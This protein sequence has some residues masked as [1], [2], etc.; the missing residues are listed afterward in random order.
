VC[1]GLSLG[2]IKADIYTS[3]LGLDYHE[4]FRVSKICKACIEG[5]LYMN[6]TSVPDILT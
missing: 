5:V 4:M 3:L 6:F 1:V 2:L